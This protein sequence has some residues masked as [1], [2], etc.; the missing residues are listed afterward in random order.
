MIAPRKLAA[1]IAREHQAPRIL[2]TQFGGELGGVRQ[3][4]SFSCGCAAL[5]N[6][7]KNLEVLTTEDEVAELAGTT[8]DG[9]S[10]GGIMD[11]ADKLG[12]NTQELHTPDPDTAWG[13]LVMYVATGF[14]VII[15][16]DK[17]DH[18]VA[19]IG[20]DGDK[21]VIQDS[22]R[23]ETNEEINGVGLFTRDEVLARWMHPES[24]TYY[25]IAF[26]RRD[27]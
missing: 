15:C 23:T 21:I 27:V 19:V 10:E 4:T 25:G 18:W 26:S 3:S 6:V 17:W 13:E 5:V 22:E 8:K 20:T 24:E 1:F 12:L 11:A 7:C 16:V 9:T 14:P 2:A